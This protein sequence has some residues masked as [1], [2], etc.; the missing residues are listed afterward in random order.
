MSAL[1]LLFAVVWCMLCGWLTACSE[2]EAYTPKP[3]AYHRL[4]VPPHEYVLYDS[5]RPYRFEI[6][7]YAK[8]R[9]DPSSFAEPHWIEVYYPAL[10]NATVSISYKPIRGD[11]DSLISF[12]YTA[13]KLTNKHNIRASSIEEYAARTPGGDRV[14]AHTLEGEVP[15]HFQFFVT[16][17]LRHFFRAAMYFPTATKSDSLAPYIDY[18]RE[19]MLHIIQTIRWNEQQKTK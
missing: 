11:Y 3:V 1:R 17:S 5:G 7:R 18:V 2:E 15:S 4:E 13:Q 14:V 16:D 12:Y 10:M 9:K 6:S 8:V 19:D